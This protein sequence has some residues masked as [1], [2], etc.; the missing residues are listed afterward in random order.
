MNETEL[1]L[2]LTPEQYNFLL[3]EA[4]SSHTHVN[5]NYMCYFDTTNGRILKDKE[6]IRVSSQLPGKM[7]C[8]ITHKSGRTVSDGVQSCEEIEHVIDCRDYTTSYNASWEPGKFVN[9]DEFLELE[10]QILGIIEKDEKIVRVNSV[11]L[12]NT[13]LKFLH[14]DVGLTLEVDQTLFPGRTDL[15]LECEFDPSIQDNLDK[16]ESLKNWLTK[17]TGQPVIYQEKGKFQRLLELL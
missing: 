10:L 4:R 17:E 2:K 5:V 15:E 14:L 8:I 11:P 13:R 12:I 1:K 9:S 6:M 3:Q 16:V 7:G